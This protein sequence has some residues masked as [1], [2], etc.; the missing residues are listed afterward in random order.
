MLSRPLASKLADALS[1]KLPWGSGGISLPT[2]ISQPS[3]VTVRDGQQATFTVTTINATSYQWQKSDDGISFSN[4]SG[5]T[6]NSYTFTTVRS[7][8]NG[9]KFRCI[10]TNTQGSVTST[11]ATLTVNLKDILAKVGTSTSPTSTGTKAV[12]G[13]GF[14]PKAV[15]PFG[16]GGTVEGP[17]VHISHHLGAATAS[18]SGGIAAASVSGVTT[19]A[20]HRR[21][22]A[23]SFI[24]SCYNGTTAAEAALQSLDAG[25]F[26]ANWSAV[27]GTAL[28]LNHICLGGADLEVS[29]TQHQ[30]NGTGAAQSFAHGLSGAPTGLLFFAVGL[31]D[32]MPTTQPT[33]FAQIG[34]WSS[35]GQFGARISSFNGLTTSQTRRIL[36]NSNV[37]CGGTTTS[38]HNM[39]VSSVDVTNVTV[40]YSGTFAN[41]RF[42]MLA[43]RGAKCQ[44]GTFYFNFSTSPVTIATPGISPRLFLPVFVPLGVQN[45]NVV[46]DD[47]NIAIGACDGTNTISCGLTDRNAQTTTNARRFQ[48][49]TSFQ[50]YNTIGTMI[51][52]S[53]AVFSG[54]SVVITPTTVNASSYGQAAYLVIGA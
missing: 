30:M 29:L 44:T 4:I 26:T 40:A 24:T 42:F 3:N 11:S 35:S 27:T 20:T 18:S 22:S 19:S 46:L 2:I 39:A 33:A 50:E 38:L 43:I 7:T 51:T 16:F 37:L 13:V 48:S 34:A 25:G 12:T 32:A 47:A 53:T 15:I 8:D 54:Q 41:I 45:L 36:S 23:T 6:T 5:A 1:R 17:L 21:H 9:D 10:C 49:S 14:Q 28:I 31:P 52:E